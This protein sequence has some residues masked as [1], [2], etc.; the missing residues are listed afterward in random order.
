MASAQISVDACRFLGVA[1]GEA[2]VLC[3]LSRRMGRKPRGSP[4][5]RK[6]GA[7]EATSQGEG[8][9]G[10]PCGGQAQTCRIA[11]LSSMA[12]VR[13]LKGSWRRG[14]GQ[15]ACSQMCVALQHMCE[16]CAPMTLRMS[17]QWSYVYTVGG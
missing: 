11:S 12:S 2:G 15:D 9:H 6:R 5:R 7:R 14:E 3:Q 17:A 10:W 13:T 16:V 1:G 4:E 8:E